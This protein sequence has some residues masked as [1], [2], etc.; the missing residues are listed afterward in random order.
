MLSHNVPANRSAPGKDVLTIAWSVVAA[1]SFLWF[2]SDSF[3]RGWSQITTDFPSYYTAARLT[4]THTPLPIFY[5]YPD[6]QREIGRAGT[7]MQ[8]GGYIPQTPLTMVPMIPLSWLQPLH[9]KRVWLILNLGFLG[10]SLRLLS[11]LT[12][13][14]V[15]QLWIV[16]F[17]G[18]GALRQNFLLG[19]YYVLLLA[20]LTVA[21][22]CLL[23]SFERSAGVALASALLLK[24][25]GAPFFF[26]LA[27]KRRF[28]ILRWRWIILTRM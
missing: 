17:I 28:R 24:L 20:V 15:A 23:R 12:R 27:A 22:Y 16:I 2:L 21:A 8:L 5:E 18:Y 9:A 13:F 11:K 7:G 1:A 14:T 3:G 25:Y 19:Q 4:T 26:F 6:F 10:L